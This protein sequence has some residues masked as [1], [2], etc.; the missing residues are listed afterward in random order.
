MLQ[1]PDDNPAH[2]TQLEDAEGD[3]SKYQ[4]YSRTEIRFLMRSILQK[5]ALITL[6]FDHGKSFILTALIAVSDDGNWIYLDYGGSQEM[7]ERALRANR[8][9]AATVLDKVKVQFAL[10]GLQATQASGRPVF[11]AKLPETVLRLQRREYFRLQA[12]IVN[13]LKCRTTLCIDGQPPR[14][15]ELVVLDISGGGVGLMLPIE[16][17][18]KLPTGTLI[19]DCHLDLPEEGSI[20]ATLCVRNAFAATNRAGQPYQRLGCEFVDLPGTSLT[21]I[22]RYITRVERERKARETG[23]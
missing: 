2:A 18:G 21:L 15:V 11:A 19:P 12:S 22:Q 17:Q 9:H 5:G 13:P 1:V 6:H 14:G 20:H 3:Y 8:L 23:D 10:D 7:N 16:Y 4:L